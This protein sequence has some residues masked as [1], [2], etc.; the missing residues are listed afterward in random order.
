MKLVF[1]VNAL[2]AALIVA[3]EMCVKDLLSLEYYM[4]KWLA[5]L[6]ISSAVHLSILWFGDRGPSS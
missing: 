5:I 2:Y 3:L 1:R 6:L 4:G